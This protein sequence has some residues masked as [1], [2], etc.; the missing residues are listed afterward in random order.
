MT[1]EGRRM[2]P[3]ALREVLRG[4]LPLGTIYNLSFFSS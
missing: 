1:A 3:A 4:L 2:G